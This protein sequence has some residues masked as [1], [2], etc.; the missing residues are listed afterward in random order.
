MRVAVI[1]PARNEALALGQVLSEIPAEAVHQVMVVDNGST[2]GTAQV[3]EEL[4]ARLISESTPGYGRAC[5]AGI[6]ALEPDIDA[7]VWLDGDHSDYAEEIPALLAPIGRGEADLVIGSRVAR[8]E[9]GSLTLQQR[10]GNRLACFLMHRLFGFRYSDLGPFRAIRREALDWLSMQDQ[11]FGWTVEMQAKAILCG[12]R[13]VE[14]PVRYRPR[15]GTSKISG[16]V[17]GTI[18]AGAAIISTIL[19]VKR[20]SSSGRSGLRGG[21]SGQLPRAQSPEP[22]ATSPTRRRLLIFLKYP[23][24]GMVKTRLAAELGDENAAAFYRASTE[25]TLT[26]LAALQSQTVLYVNP[27]DAVGR[28]PQWLGA[29]W[30]VRAQEGASLGDRLRQATNEAFVQGAKHVVVIGTDS[31]W[32][33]PRQIAEAFTA[34][35]R[36][37]VVIGPTE[38]GGYYLIGFSRPAPELF[39][40]VAWSSPQVHA[41]TM[42]RAQALGLSVHVLPHGYD[43]DYLKDVERFLEE[44]RTRGPLA[45]AVQVIEQLLSQRRAAC[46]S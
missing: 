46:Q 30:T 9:P 36:A 10:V 16:T 6:A 11:A 37:D 2:D 15:I 13:V 40:G 27:P 42:A 12:L 43:L 38:D 35:G 3:A 29:E 21:G 4:G 28:L 14:V 25:L 41:Q 18:L 20:I 34:L 19:K 8:A 17:R 39:D 45:A 1:I 31:P 33:G 44:E 23:T 22:A 26:R 32:I 7:V 24:P 5:L